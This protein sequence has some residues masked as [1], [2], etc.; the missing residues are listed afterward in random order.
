MTR[1]EA[2]LEGHLAGELG[3]EEEREFVALLAQE[4]H[5]R[6]FAAHERTA[7]LLA[8]ARRVVPLSP[9]FTEEVMARL[10]DRRTSLWEKALEILWARRALHWNLA[11]ALALGLVLA[12][13]PLGWRALP[14]RGP[15]PTGPRPAATVIRFTLHAPGAERVS[16]V[17]DFNGWRSEEIL[18]SDTSGRGHFS[19]ALPLKPGRYAYMFVVDGT[20]WVTDPAAEDHRDD[21][22]GNRNAVVTVSDIEPGND[23]T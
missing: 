9:S 6:A 2:L 19:G 4:E 16:L 13:A 3:P 17:G 11:S 14:D 8:G 5:R 15:A 10:P 12:V 7:A 1:F 22:F 18:L 20:T 23:D 21:G